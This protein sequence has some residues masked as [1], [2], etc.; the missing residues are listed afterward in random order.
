[1]KKNTL[2][3]TGIRVSRMCFG[4]L[5]IGPTQKNK[6][7][8]ESKEI[9]AA[10][11]DHGV[12]FFDTADLY[13][14]YDHLRQAIDLKRDVVISTK[15]YDYTAEGV[16]KS[17][18]RALTELGRDYVDLYLLHEQESRLT[19]EGHWEAIEQL[20]KFKEAGVVRAIGISTHRI[21]GVIGATLFPELDVIHPLINLTG[22]GIEDGTAQEMATAIHEAKMKGKGIYAMKPLGGGNLLAQKQA[23]FD[24]ILALDDLDA[25]AI[26]VQ[27]VDE[28]LYDVKKFNGETIPEE[29]ELAVAGS[30]KAIH[31]SDWCEGCGECARHCSSKAI[32]IVDGKAAIDHEKCI[33]CCYCSTYCKLFCIKVI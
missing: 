28:V 2:G 12:D 33:L 16:K 7:L 29:L 23:C 26:G 15:S 18:H 14:N 9:I 32:T 30:S 19:I 20:I 1:M 17:L 13:N 4:S 5:T 24:F 21:E 10:A 31:I 8:A 27:S 22:I 3:N 11:L 25:I 6:S